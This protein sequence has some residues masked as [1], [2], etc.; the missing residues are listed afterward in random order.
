M[1]RNCPICERQPLYPIAI[2]G[3][4]IETCSACGGLWF[5]AGKLERFP[6]RPA[7]KTL[8]PLARQAPG[9]CRR[10]G[11]A[12]SRAMARCTACG[13]AP[14]QCPTCSARLA[15]V[16][17]SACAI[18]VCVH[19]E[20]VWLDAGEFEALRGIA[21]PASV[22]GRATAASSRGWEIPA[23]SAPIKD[24]WLGPGQVQ[25]PQRENQIPNLRA[26]FICRQC[27]ASIG[28]GD[29]W[30]HQGEIYCQRCHPPGAVSGHDLPSDSEGEQGEEIG[31]GLG[32]PLI[33]FLR[34]LFT[35]R[36]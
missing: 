25:A 13:G 32:H 34:N 19:C 10:R 14:A 18:D 8:L 5:E 27:G 6:D 28:V 3:V 12:V 21:G 31:G 17:T 33:R 16:P 9:R 29:A 1:S 15:M 7:T 30:A 26:P 20:S 22:S 4:E 23:P 35:G 24:P 2:Q 36:N 11:H